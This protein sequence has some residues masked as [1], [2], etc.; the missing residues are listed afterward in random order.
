MLRRTKFSQIFSTYQL[1]VIIITF[2]WHIKHS[3][4]FT[5]KLLKAQ[6]FAKRFTHEPAQSVTKI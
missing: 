6:K 2:L 4:Y 5:L 3:K 1:V